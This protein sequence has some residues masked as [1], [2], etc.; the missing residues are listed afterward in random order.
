MR[1]SQYRDRKQRKMNYN[2]SF[3]K[4]K[5]KYIFI[6]ESL[7]EE[8]ERKKKLE[9]E[10]EKN[11][12]IYAYLNSDSS[13]KYKVSIFTKT[14]YVILER[15]ESVY[16]WKANAWFMEQTNWSSFNLS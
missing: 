5:L 6:S 4:E 13:K 10:E 9:E 11:N 7:Q 14:H 8:E 1:R 2:R 12:D 3:I 15:K 16:I